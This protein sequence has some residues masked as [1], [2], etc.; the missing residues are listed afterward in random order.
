MREGRTSS[1]HHPF[2]EMIEAGVF[3]P[4]TGMRKPNPE[5]DQF[6]AKGEYVKAKHMIAELRQQADPA[7]LLTEVPQCQLDM[8]VATMVPDKAMPMEAK[9]LEPGSSEAKVALLHHMINLCD[10]EIRMHAGRW[11]KYESTEAPSWATQPQPSWDIAQALE[12]RTH[13]SDQGSNFLEFH[14]YTDEELEDQRKL[15]L[16][17]RWSY[18]KGSFFAYEPAPADGGVGICWE[19]EVQTWTLPTLL[20]V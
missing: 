10:G 11:R 19:K 8:H 2:G 20:G 16:R 3:C 4:L 15:G 12:R 13:P 14:M 9:K 5:L 18:L 6:N 1:G 7:K 17:P